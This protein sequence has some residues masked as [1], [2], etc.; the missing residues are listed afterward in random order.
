[1]APVTG[2]HI[3]TLNGPIRYMFCN[4]AFLSSPQCITHH[5]CNYFPIIWC[6]RNIQLEQ[7]TY[8]LMCLEMWNP[9]STNDVSMILS[10]LVSMIVSTRFPPAMFI[11]NS[12]YWN[13]IAKHLKIV[14]S[15]APWSLQC[16]SINIVWAKLCLNPELSLS[17]TNL[18]YSFLRKATLSKYSF[19]WGCFILANNHS[20]PLHKQQTAL[21]V[22]CYE[23]MDLAW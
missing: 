2:R 16:C 20:Y 17:S 18:D 3:Y 7:W 21:V 1:M 13:N 8:E 15:T 9:I 19:R 4:N 14:L 22:S 12:Q 11:E 23:F 5:K 6:P 10:L